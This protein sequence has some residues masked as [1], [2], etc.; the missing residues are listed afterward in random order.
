MLEEHHFELIHGLL[1]FNLN[2][3]IRRRSSALR[4]QQFKAHSRIRLH[5]VFELIRTVQP[6]KL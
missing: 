6:S 3:C 1:I 2:R 4:E 5:Q